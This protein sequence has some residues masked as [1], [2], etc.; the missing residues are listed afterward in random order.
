[1]TESAQIHDFVAFSTQESYTIAALRDIVCCVAEGAYVHLYFLGD[2]DLL[3]AKGLAKLEAFLPAEHFVRVHH[4]AIV[5]LR[6]IRKVLKGG[7][8][9][10]LLSNGMKITI[11]GR[12][13]KE[14]MGRLRVF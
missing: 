10:L 1:M 13:R 14:M 6:H 3:L 9:L 5:N 12:R 11:A 2:E 8:N 7:E 4:N